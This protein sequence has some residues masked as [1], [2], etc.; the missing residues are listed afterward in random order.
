MLTIL[1]DF[2]LVLISSQLPKKL[3][4]NLSLFLYKLFKNNG[5]FYFQRITKEDFETKAKKQCWNMEKYH[6]LNDKR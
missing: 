1:F 4:Y 6:K 5:F 2:I 3:K